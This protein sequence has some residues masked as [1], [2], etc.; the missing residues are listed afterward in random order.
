MLSVHGLFGL[1]KVALLL[2]TLAG[3]VL[4]FTFWLVVGVHRI[5]VVR[6]SK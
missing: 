6:G 1:R 5:R 3:T 4:S 2:M